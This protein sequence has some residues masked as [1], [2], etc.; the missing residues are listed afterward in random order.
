MKQVFCWNKTFWL[1]KPMICIFFF[2]GFAQAQTGNTISGFVFDAKT[3]QPVAD[4]YVELLN[5]VYIAV[6][7]VKTDG[8]GRFFFAGMPAGTFTVKILPYG[9]N[10]SEAEQEAIVTNF[11]V[12]NNVS[13]DNVYLDFYLRLDSRKVNFGELNPAGVVFAQD[14]PSD[15]KKLYEKA[16]SQFE[17][18]KEIELAFENL[19]KA[20]TI[21]PTYYLA[22]N[23]IGI[24]YVRRNQFYESLPY[25]IKSI[26]VN[27][28]SFTSFYALGIA[29]YSLKSWKEASEAFRATTILAPQ[30]ALAHLKYGMVLRIDGNYKEAEKSLLKA[31]DL[32]K[33]SP[34]EDIHWELGLLYEKTGRFK[35]AAD[36]LETY[37]KVA[38]VKKVEQKKIDTIK[39]LIVDLRKRAAG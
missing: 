23:R 36:E 9:T 21:F 24:E 14:I 22:L 35:E 16:V 7:R 18:N 17:K 33:N 8:G 2:V 15:A 13:S 5:E 1:L 10:Y 25:L 26:E 6:R 11:R 4:I 28:K 38:D 3:R 12:G 32:T 39:N 31:K 30:S 37:L 29:A 19:K 20:I 27:G 34:V